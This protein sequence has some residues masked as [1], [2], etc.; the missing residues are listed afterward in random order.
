MRKREKCHES[1]EMYAVIKY[2]IN[3]TKNKHAK[4]HKDECPPTGDMKKTMWG[5]QASLSYRNTTV[6]LL[7]EPLKD[8]PK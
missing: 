5:H 6:F 7:S 8:K 2:D 3:P 1:P 4:Q